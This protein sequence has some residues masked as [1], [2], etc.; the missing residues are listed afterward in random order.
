MTQ[1][2]VI[3]LV[4]TFLNLIS[5]A[6][7]NTEKKAESNEGV[8]SKSEIAEIKVGLANIQEVLELCGDLNVAAMVNQTS[9]IND[10]HLVD[11]LLKRNVQLKQIFAPEHGFR[12]NADAGEDVKDNVDIQSGLPII[13]LYGINKKPSPKQLED[14]DIILFDIQDVGARFYTY[15]SSMHY[16]MDAAAEN[17]LKMIVLDR[18]NPNGHYVDGP[19]LEK[20]FQSFVGIHEIPVVH[21]MTVG[22]IAMM[23]KGQSWL[24]SKNELDLAVV[25]CE[26]YDHKSK[27]QLS[28]PPSPNLP[29]MKAIYLYPSLCLFEGTVV[30]VGRGTRLPFQIFG[31]PSFEDDSFTFTP[32]PGYGGEASKTQR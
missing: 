31:H 3:I 8:Q 32:K 5:C 27:Y 9:V 7:V 4:F 26:N 11:T 15:I 25:K 22:E 6:Q 24:D 29:N 10:V 13:S 21:G 18:P 30:S 20:E 19:V 14:I 28:I 1:R 2:K 12:G 23:I 17:G 16:L